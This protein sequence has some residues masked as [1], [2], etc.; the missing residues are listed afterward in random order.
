MQDIDSFIKSFNTEDL[1]I[2]HDQTKF[3]ML[4]F[5]IYR[6]IKGD[7][8]YGD[9]VV[10][11]NSGSLN[12]ARLEYDILVSMQNVFP[13][14]FV[15]FGATGLIVMPYLLFN[16]DN[17]KDFIE[18]CKSAQLEVNAIKKLLLNGYYNFDLKPDNIMVYNNKKVLIDFDSCISRDDFN[19]YYPTTNGCAL[20]FISS[21]GKVFFRN[22]DILKSYS[23][24]DMRKLADMLQLDNLVHCI[25]KLIFPESI[26][27]KRYQKAVP[28][29][30][31]IIIQQS[32]IDLLPD[33]INLWPDFFEKQYSLDLNIFKINCDERFVSYFAYFLMSIRKSGMRY[34]SG[35]GD[36]SNVLYTL[37][38]RLYNL[39]YLLTSY[40]GPELFNK[41][42]FNDE[43][44]E[45]CK[46]NI[47]YFN[48]NYYNFKNSNKFPLMRIGYSVNKIN[49]SYNRESSLRQEMGG[50][51]DY[52]LGNI[53]NI[54]I[55]SDGFDSGYFCKTPDFLNLDLL[56]QLINNRDILFVFNELDLIIG[57]AKFEK[58]IIFMM[59]IK[60][61]IIKLDN[62][63]CTHSQAMDR[64]F[65]EVL[66]IV[67]KKLGN[68]KGFYIDGDY[69]DYNYIDNNALKDSAD[70]IAKKL[71]SSSSQLNSN[72]TLKCMGIYMYSC[73]YFISAVKENCIRIYNWFSYKLKSKNN[74]QEFKKS[75]AIFL[76]NKQRRKTISFIDKNRDLIISR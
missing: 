46:E 38:S 10:K 15:E 64:S 45:I 60:Y 2:V 67:R 6:N 55:E 47:R 28:V 69:I 71:Y 27:E 8:F 59:I 7:G 43:S 40:P 25:A 3:K 50:Y 16:D 29:G 20:R 35:G 58:Q 51:W 31:N 30:S 56:N 24:Q 4:S 74:Q 33:S 62:G 66:A 37:S 19:L 34:I 53:D 21:Y 68:N 73:S 11:I 9:F 5:C 49:N 61:I 36:I 52:D 54:S 32:I 48:N 76:A 41:I 18:I 23:Q 75:Q 26:S 57:R 44:L 65:F 1:S 39:E 17:P 70:L 14:R 12:D 42:S 22:L 63:L 13:V 72:K